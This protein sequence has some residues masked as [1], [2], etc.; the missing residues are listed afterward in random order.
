MATEI[1]DVA[2]NINTVLLEKELQDALASDTKYKQVDNMKKRAVKTA[3]DYSEFKA[4]V[5]CAHLK[6]I[7]SKEVASLSDAKKGWKHASAV[8][9]SG[10]AQLLVTVKG[11][12][13]TFASSSVSDK[14]I[15][16]PKTCM[17]LERELRR[18]KSDSKKIL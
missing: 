8:D 1:V 11:A 12:Q 16:Y 13:H 18:I 4:M 3:S 5:A 17:E 7:S 9:N 14:T 15:K 2:G 10:S 6:K